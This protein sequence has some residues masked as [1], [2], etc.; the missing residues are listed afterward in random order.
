MIKS[1]AVMILKHLLTYAQWGF[2]FNLLISLLK[3]SMSLQCS[4]TQADSG[5]AEAAR[6]FCSFSSV[7]SLGEVVPVLSFEVPP[8]V[9]QEAGLLV[10]F[11]Q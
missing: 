3:L 2:Y 10:A 9:K 6:P 11:S 5:M 8:L 1:K 4:Y 7:K